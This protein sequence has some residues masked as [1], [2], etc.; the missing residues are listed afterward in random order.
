MKQLGID[1]GKNLMKDNC[2]AFMKLSVLMAKE[3]EEGASTGFAEG[4][5]KRIDSKDFNYFIL[6]DGSNNEKSFIWLRQFTGSDKFTSN[7]SK[8]INS[9]LKIKW[10][11]IEVYIPSAKNYY[12]IKEVV[13]IE[14]L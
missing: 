12:K 11:E 4:K 1:V 13:G 2:E 6:T 8:Y 3:T 7:S 14:V 10:Q 9:K 5:L